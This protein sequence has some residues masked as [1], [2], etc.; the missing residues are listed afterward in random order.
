[1]KTIIMQDTAC[2]PNGNFMA[3]SKYD[4]GKHISKEQA[5]AFV[6]GRHATYETAAAPRAPETTS[7]G[8]AKVETENTAKPKN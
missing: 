1:M 3:G 2:G 7:Q 6:K 8:A 4:V 5:E